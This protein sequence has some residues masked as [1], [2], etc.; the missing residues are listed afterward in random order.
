MALLT[1]LIQHPDYVCDS[2]LGYM[3]EIINYSFK[4][5]W[6]HSWE[7]MN[8]AFPH[9]NYA[10]AQKFCD[11]MMSGSTDMEELAQINPSVRR[12]MPGA[13][14][15]ANF[16]TAYGPRL[17]SQL[18]GNLR[19][20]QRDNSRRVVFHILDKSDDFL[21]DINTNLEYPCCSDIVIFKRDAD[22]GFHYNIDVVA[23]FRSSNAYITMLYDLYNISKFV[24]AFVTALG[25]LDTVSY[26]L[27][28]LSFQIASSHIY[29][30]NIEQAKKLIG[31]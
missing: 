5:E 14:I 17:L 29:A 16:S 9:W 1:E 10:Y 13:E 6:P 19:E 11:W 2:R 30:N 31:C 21:R 22:I 24:E 18:E 27:N 26:K 3:N 7:H 12:F 4:C 15:P 8:K 25:R 20:I 28:S 23:T